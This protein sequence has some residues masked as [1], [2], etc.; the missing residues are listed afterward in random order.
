MVDGVGRRMF[1]SSGLF[2][3]ILGMEKVVGFWG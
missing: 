2:G 3:Q 1:G